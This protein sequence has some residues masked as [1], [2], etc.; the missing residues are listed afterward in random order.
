VFASATVAGDGA[1]S[2]VPA[3]GTVVVPSGSGRV[4]ALAASDGTRAWDA[5]A[6]AINSSPTVSDGVVYVG[7]YTGGVR[8]LA[9]GDGT[10][11]WSAPSVG[12]VAS[13]PTVAGS[14]VVV[15]SRD[16]SV[17]GLDAA[18]GEVRWSYET[19]GA[20]ES[21][22]TVVDGAAYVGS[23]DGSVSA[24]DVGVEASSDGSRVRL[25]TLGHH[26]TWADRA[27]TDDGNGGQQTPADTATPGD[28]AT[29]TSDSGSG[30]DGPGFGVLGT[31]AALGGAGYLLDR[32]HSE[33]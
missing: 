12:Q 26:G 10:E 33:E 31:L 7:S 3:G 28:T 32:R 9:L 27:A 23:R 22:P 15:G 16:G 8:A 6:G 17:Y 14:V 25:G 2:D 11:E 24:L 13:S 5:D 21:S 30:E 19:G 20:V 4:Y 18:G 1:S 29:P